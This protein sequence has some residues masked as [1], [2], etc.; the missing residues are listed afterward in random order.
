MSYRFQDQEAVPT[1]IRRMAEEQVEAAAANLIRPLEDPDE[2]VHDTRKRFKKTRA[3][4]RLVRKEL[5]SEAYSRENKAYRDLGRLL[6]S[7]RESAVLTETAGRFQEIFDEGLDRRAF[8]VFQHRLRE[9]HE[10]ILEEAL[11]LDG[12]VDQVRDG[13]EEAWE[14]IRDWPLKDRGF[15]TMKA[16]LKKVY[17]RGRNRM[18]D[19]YADPSGPRFHQWRKRVKYHWYHIR[20][21]RPTWDDVLESR[22]DAIHDLADLLGEGN[23]L[24]DLLALLEEEPDLV[25]SDIVRRELVRHAQERRAGLWRDARPLGMKIYQET[26]GE[27]AERMEGYWESSRKAPVKAG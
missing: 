10:G 1:G 25:P 15:R 11:R 16:S 7:V 13:A 19:A 20:I 27:F 4:L 24:T 9:R 18:E 5:G 17:K 21:L 12:P 22:A 3:V 6:S 8:Q 14:R 26:P 23:D 2:A